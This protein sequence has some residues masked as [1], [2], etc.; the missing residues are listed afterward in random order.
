MKKIFSVD[1]IALAII[2]ALCG[3]LLVGKFSED[4][5]ANRES[6]TELYAQQAIEA[7]ERTQEAVADILE[8]CYQNESLRE[9]L[10]NS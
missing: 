1:T 3:L 5:N 6:L 10:E 2:I 7:G 8:A 4:V 9:V